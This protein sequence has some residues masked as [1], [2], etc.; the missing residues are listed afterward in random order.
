MMMNSTKELNRQ[1]AGFNEPKQQQ[2]KNR[3]YTPNREYSSFNFHNGR[4]F[5]QYYPSFEKYA[6]FLMHF[7]FDEKFMLLLNECVEY[8]ISILFSILF[9]ACTHSHSRFYGAHGFM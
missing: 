1:G 7:D 5:S 6:K 2:K 4:I 3:K 9:A 8:M